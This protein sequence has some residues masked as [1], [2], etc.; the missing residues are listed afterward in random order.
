MANNIPIIKRVRQTSWSL[1]D[2]IEIYYQQ[3]VQCPMGL[4]KIVSI[5]QEDNTV[6]VMNKKD[7]MM[8]YPSRNI[9]VKI[10]PLTQLQ[11]RNLGV[12][13][14]LALGIDSFS[15]S[16]KRSMRKISCVGQAYTVEI[17]I[18]P[19]FGLRVVDKKGNPAEAQNLGYITL[20][21]TSRG[22]DLFNMLRT[23]Y[24]LIASGVPRQ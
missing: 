1:I 22:F 16:V 18:K 5:S 14:N 19:S 24:A 23:T 2:L 8:T 13:A 20:Y 3:D 7:K 6:T 17:I 9:K 15:Y 4:A 21:L 12:I 10:R 11:G